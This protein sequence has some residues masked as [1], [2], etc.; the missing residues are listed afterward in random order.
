VTVLL[1][2]KFYLPP[3]PA[4]F[5]ERPQLLEKLDGVLSHRMTLVSAPAG[6]G[7]SVLISDW[8]Q[9]ARKKGV[10]FGW[11][12]L[13]DADNDPGRFLEYLV[14]SLEEGGMLLDAAT[15]PTKSGEKVQI[16]E[17][18]A[19]L[20]RGIMSFKLEIVL[21]LDDYYLISNQEVHTS[22]EYLIEH[23]PVHLHIVILTRSDPPFELA[24][25]R[26]TGQ[27][28]EI[29]MEHLRFSIKETSEFLSKSA[30]VQLTE[31]EVIALNERTEGWIAGLQMAAISLLGS[32]DVSAF[33]AAFAGSHRYIFDYLLEQVL[34]R[35][36]A[37][38]REFLLKTSVLE[39][40]SPPL[41]NAIAETGRTTH[42]FLVDL[43]RNNLF[44]VPLDDERRWYRYHHL[45]SDLLRLML[46]QTYPGLSYKLHQRACQWYEAHGMLPE[47]LHH[48]LSSGDMRLVAQIVSANV[49]VLVENDEVAPTLQKI[50]SVPYDEMIAMPWLII[51]RAWVMGAGQ[52]QKSFQ[53]LDVAEKSSENLP[54]GIERQR[55][56]AHIAAARAF[57]S[58]LQGDADL[59]IANAR[60]ANELLPTEEYA[61]RALNLTIWGDILS[62]DRRNDRLV[63]PILDQA[64]ELAHQAKKPHVAM[65]ASQVMATAHLHA[66]RLGEAHRVCLEALAIAEDYQRRYQRHLSLTPVIYSLLGRIL[67]EWGENEKAVQFARKGLTLSE[68]DGQYFNYVNCLC[69]LGRILVL[70]NDLEQAHQVFQRADNA[71][72]KISPWFWQN[73]IIF[74]LDSMLD[75]EA[76]DPSEISQQLHRL[77]ETGASYPTLLSARLMLRDNQAN[78]ALAALDQALSELE[79]QPSFIVTW[80]YALRA[81][82]FQD[83]GEIKNALAS[84]KQALELGEPENRVATFLREG[85]AMEKLLK[86]ARAKSIAPT[87]VQRLL[88]AFESRRKQKPESTPVSEALIEPL[89]ERELEILQHLNSYLSTPEIADLLVVSANTVRTH[90]K[91]IYGKLGVH[92]RSRAVM[93]ARELGLLV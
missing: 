43:E 86:L 19:G 67:A 80:I 68:F 49:L 36:T 47:A 58:G 55:L 32:V 62:A 93:R 17:I 51:A 61:V 73:S 75:S 42:S 63:M 27:L 52:T 10:T 33:V 31:T 90:I 84:L 59:T 79:G 87:F 83:M 77:R 1:P 12:S 21:I 25:L 28:V 7:K 70:G 50:D 26:V 5:V 18:L 3:K 29:R 91:N 9:S 48:A 54:D 69:Y 4:A 44:L 16:E 13:D 30:G 39:R 46:E 66:G 78:K 57:V 76:P 20:I 53:M 81:L 40:L 74:N 41:C 34:N 64:V 2:T 71:A 89:S 72:Q 92:G 85:P 60:L 45:F 22:L 24:R 88:A 6:A 8:V 23:A 35:Q 37:E 56:K 15:F 82:A 38:V 14:A 65:I 11:L